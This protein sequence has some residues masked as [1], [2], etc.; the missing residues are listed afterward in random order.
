MPKKK[1]AKQIW[2]AEAIYERLREGTVKENFKFGLT[3]YAERILSEYLDGVLV[4]KDDVAT[5]K[6]FLT[7]FALGLL[8]QSRL[9]KILELVRTGELPA[10]V[11]SD[12]FLLEI[13]RASGRMNKT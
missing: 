11:P 6:L 3:A 8:D 13:G 1:N 4:R 7:F 9:Q 5:E 2:L 10:S 12:K